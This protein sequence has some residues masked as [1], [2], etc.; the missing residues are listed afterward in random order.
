MNP[1]HPSFKLS[2]SFGK[3]VAGAPAGQVADLEWVVEYLQKN[4]HARCYLVGG[5]VRDR[6]LGQVCR[7]FDLEV[8][9]IAPDRFAQTMEALGAQGVGKSFYVYRYRNLD[10]SLPR[11]EVKTGYG[12]K[13]FTVSLA[14][15]LREASRRRDFTINALLYDMQTEQILDFYGGIEDLRHRRLRVVDQ[16]HFKDDSLRVLRAVQF[17]ARMGLRIE[18]ETCLL[19]RSISLDDLP[20]ERIFGELEK[21]FLGEHLAHGLY[22]LIALECLQKLFG[23]TVD[24]PLFIRLMRRL[25]RFGAGIKPQLRPYLLPYLLALETPISIEKFLDRLGAPKRYRIKL[26]NT[27]RIPEMVTPEFVATLARQEGVGHSICGADPEV[28]RI[29]RSLG[30]WEHP[31][32]IGVT[33]RELMALGFSGRALGEELERRFHLKVAALQHQHPKEMNQK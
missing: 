6:L 19:C 13:G 20:K 14:S 26:L 16:A 15:S 24:R 33:P 32:E 17:A 11:H 29:A 23:I 18:P 28:S 5:A 7:D 25:I 2:F 31:L 22:Y 12:H 21:C 8:Y 27:P 3:M 30:I 10:I 9:G 1:D 4:H